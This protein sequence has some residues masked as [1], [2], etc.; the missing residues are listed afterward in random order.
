MIT[1]TNIVLISL[2]TVLNTPKIYIF[3]HSEHLSESRR[4]RILKCIRI[5][6]TSSNLNMQKRFIYIVSRALNVRLKK[7]TLTGSLI[8]VDEI[9]IITKIIAGSSRRYFPNSGKA[10]RNKIKE[11]HVT[12]A[13]LAHGHP[14]ERR[15]QHAGA[16]VGAHL[17]HERELRVPPHCVVPHLLSVDNRKNTVSHL[18]EA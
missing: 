2:W 7:G 3:I 12:F 1:S 5:Y 13:L 14:H 11:E 15:L 16:G 10:L 17:A 4:Y 9:T 8:V 6:C 18:V